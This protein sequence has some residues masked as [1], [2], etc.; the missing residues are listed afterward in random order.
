MA[1][2]L[3]QESKNLDQDSWRNQRVKYIQIFENE[4]C[5]KQKFKFK[6][7]KSIIRN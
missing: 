4:S 2:P 3:N 7:A 5:K 6:L 1:N